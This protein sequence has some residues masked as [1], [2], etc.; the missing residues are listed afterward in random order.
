MKYYNILEAKVKKLYIS[1]SYF[2]AI[3]KI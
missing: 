3:N 1:L 2:V